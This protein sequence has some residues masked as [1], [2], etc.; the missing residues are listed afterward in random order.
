MP[1][2]GHPPSGCRSEIARLKW[3]EHNNVTIKII[4]HFVDLEYGADRNGVK[5]QSIGLVGE[6][7]LTEPVAVALDNPNGIGSG[8]SLCCLVNCRK[9]VAPLSGINF[10]GEGHFA[11]PYPRRLWYTR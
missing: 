9:V 8:G 6:Q 11:P 4:E 10:E 7:G 2:A 5:A 1:L 3:L